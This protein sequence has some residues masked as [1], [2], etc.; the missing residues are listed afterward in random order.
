MTSAAV[1][2]GE[3]QGEREIE[4]CNRHSVLRSE[5]DRKAVPAPEVDYLG[6]PH[7][8]PAPR[9]PSCSLA[10]CDICVHMR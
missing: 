1:V 10:P 2:R 5:K 9:S 3:I 8:A 7:T 4:T 6:H